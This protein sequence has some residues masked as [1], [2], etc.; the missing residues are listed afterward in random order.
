MVD[1]M[2]IQACQISS[3]IVTAAHIH[4]NV[5]LNQI[6]NALS[7]LWNFTAEPNSLD[8]LFFTVF[9]VLVIDGFPFGAEWR[10]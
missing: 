10:K 5:D 4:G 9:E 6:T 2:L 7:V 8:I 3:C 1:M